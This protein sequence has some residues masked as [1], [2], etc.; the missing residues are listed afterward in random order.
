MISNW[1]INTHEWYATKKSLVT[2]D[3]TELFLYQNFT[4]LWL[5]VVVNSEIVILFK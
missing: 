1:F 5:Y 3:I 2:S 4:I